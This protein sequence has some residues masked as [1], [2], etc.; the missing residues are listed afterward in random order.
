MVMMSLP[1]LSSRTLLRL[2]L[3]RLQEQDDAVRLARTLQA[4]TLLATRVRVRLGGSDDDLC[5]DSMPQTIWAAWT[6]LILHVWRFEKYVVT[7][8]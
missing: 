5:G 2:S 8:L 7:F 3:C 4:P 6:L 1:S